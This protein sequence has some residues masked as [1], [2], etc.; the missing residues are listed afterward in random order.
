[1]AGIIQH[2]D[3]PASKDAVVGTLNLSSNG[4]P[5]ARVSG[6]SAGTARWAA[7]DVG[8]VGGPRL[9][10]DFLGAS[11]T[12]LPAPL[13]TQDTS[14]GGT[15]TL[16]YVNDAAGG[17]YQL[18]L[19]AD[20]EAEAITLYQGDQLTFD[21]TKKPVLDLRVKLEPDVT[22]TSGN[23]A[24]GDKI[25]MGLAANRNATL[26]NVVTNAWFMFAGANKNIY[27]ETD[28]GT[29]DDDD[30]D[31]G[32]DW[33]ANTYLDLRID[34]SDLSAVKFSV[35]GEVVGVGSLADATGNVQL[36]IEVTKAA[37]ANNDHRL[38]VDYV[39]LRSNR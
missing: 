25:V 37:A 18:K 14:T 15:P 21:I 27:W 2:T 38:T 4:H 8:P 7:V 20:N 1:M 34:C 30:N 32:V 26:D 3:G 6:A 13:A 35:N 5:E 33:V 23:T 16:A 39:D 11:G 22:G 9:V 17:A 31:T 10:E 12:T 36:F 29:T 28:D 19:A 24:A